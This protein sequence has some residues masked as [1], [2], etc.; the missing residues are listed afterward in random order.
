MPGYD[1]TGPMGGGP[2]TGGGFGY[3]NPANTGNRPLGMGGRGRGRGFRGRAYA[4]PAAYPPAYPANTADPG[5]GTYSADIEAEI[6]ALKKDRQALEKK[7]DALTEAVSRLSK[8]T[9]PEKKG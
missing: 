1:G 9:K 4:S 3:C 7:L 2:M 8:N 6:A 5:A